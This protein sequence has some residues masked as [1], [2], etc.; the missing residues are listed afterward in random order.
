MVVQRIA[1]AAGAAQ[2]EHVPV[3]DDL[4]LGFAEDHRAHLL[5]AVRQFARA[6]VRI[7]QWR[8]AAEPF[9]VPAAGREAPAPGD[10]IAA[11]DDNR[12]ASSRQVRT[13]GKD[14]VAIAED[15]LRGFLRQ[16]R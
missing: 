12:A 7:E 1:V 14:A 4:R 3:V 9:G 5:A 2:T 6:A 8:M 15:L 16:V 10:A 11:I 13:P